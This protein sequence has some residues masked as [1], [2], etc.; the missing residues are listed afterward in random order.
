MAAHIL[1]L[2]ATLL[3]GA[4]RGDP[5]HV[6]RTVVAF[7][8]LALATGA[9]C[10]GLLTLRSAPTEVAFVVT[11]LAG[12]A[13]TAGF[14]AAPLIAGAVDP[15]DP[16]RFVLFDVR[17]ASLASLLALAGLISVPILGLVALGVCL[18]IVWT[19]H[20][21]PWVASAVGVVLGV[22]TCGLLARVCMALVAM[23]LR[24]R[25]SRELTG[26]FIL[27]ILV[28]VVPVGLFLAS[29]QWGGRVPTQL[30][31]AADIL[32][33][34]PLGAAW[35]LPARVAAGDA[36]AW[37]SLVVAVASVALLGAAWAW[38]VQRVLT[39]TERPESGR[40]RSG[41]GWFAVA[42]GNAGGAVAARSLVYWLRDP[43]YLMNLLIV[44]IAALLA[45]FPL[46]IAGVPF[47][48]VVLVPVPIVALFFG[49]LPHND[50]AYDSTA[51][52]LHIAS[53][54][55]GVADRLGRIVPML[56]I[57]L[58]VLA[59][60]I[61][62]AIS[63]HGRWALLPA[64][65]GV[66]ASLFLGG[67]G[68]SSIS[69]AVAPYPVS[70]PGESPFQQPERVGSSAPITQAVVLLG[71]IV[72]AAPSL[73]WAWLAMSHDISYAALGMWGGIAIGLAVLLV[74]V[75]VGSLAFERRGGRLMEFAES[76]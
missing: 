70:R 23:F 9:G 46:L 21:V 26:L 16:R 35:A 52:W 51:V 62:L 73:W 27:A 37:L 1:R 45:M 33:D 29:L 7:V 61:P 71:A 41:L 59:V 11:V 65:V 74:G 8:L 20:E 58:P 4:L 38:I 24:G 72:V 42:P 53:G 25:R 30:A 49:W 60:C 28:V 2:R 5:S 47:A 19:A 17:P 68:L 55:R 39:T 15:L 48:Y 12:S 6:V 43:R 36:S 56:L 63:L 13:L 54:T 44:P 50:L 3:V 76:G 14:V 67:L 40:E 18:V 32:A 57:G 31:Q 34:T 10:W 69:S 22:V 64:M 66:C 75:A